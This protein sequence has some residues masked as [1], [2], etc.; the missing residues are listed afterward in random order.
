[1]TKRRTQWYVLLTIVI[2]LIGMPLDCAGST[3]YIETQ[4]L[5]I[6]N[7][8]HVDDLGFSLDV[9]GGYLISGAINVADSVGN[10]VGAA[11]VYRRDSNDNWIEEAR[12]MPNDGKHNDAFG[13]VVGIDGQS[14]IVGVP[15]N[16]A[17]GDSSGAAYIFANRNSGGWEQIIKL[18]PG[19]GARSDQFGNSVD[20][21]GRVAV[22]GAFGHQDSPA[23]GVSLPKG[24]V[25]VYEDNESSGWRFS[26]KLQANDAVYG[27]RFG[28]QVAIAGDTLVAT[29]PNV[30]S[31]NSDWRGAAYIFRRSGNHWSQVAKL[32]PHD[33]QGSG[34][35]GSSVAISDGKV[36]VGALGSS[37]TDYYG[38]AY[39][40]EESVEGV[41]A[42]TTQL[43]PRDIGDRY[44]GDVALSE[45]LAVLSARSRTSQEANVAYVFQ[46]GESGNW[47]ELATLSSS[48]GA[49]D[50]GYSLGIDSKFVFA[51]SGINS[52]GAVHV[53]SRI[54]EPNTSMSC[55][56]ATIL[57]CLTRRQRLRRI[58]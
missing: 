16:D 43:I 35:F 30:K 2:R 33:P 58:G 53:F 40:F 22:V 7:P 12:L 56:M 6:S 34:T 29:A 39:M 3:P 1:M 42:Q 49:F 14:A 5:R 50:F 19:D 47:S 4:T 17:L 36:L 41:W 24:A 32:S 37:T 15:S 38:G 46:R 18:V 11:F 20:L 54:P 57:G 51:G 44:Y 52:P 27:D 31:I 9:D 8:G 45:N 48:Q 26:S 23:P 28:Y 21:S 13:D 55:L 25:Y 10:D